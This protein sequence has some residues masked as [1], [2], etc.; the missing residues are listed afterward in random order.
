MSST[1]WPL[2][3]DNAGRADW[4]S[5]L[6]LWFFQVFCL[7]CVSSKGLIVLL[8]HFF[9]ELLNRSFLL[10][11]PF[12]S[13]ATSKLSDSCFDPRWPLL[14]KRTAK[15]GQRHNTK[16]CEAEDKYMLL[17]VSLKIKYVITVS[18]SISIHAPLTSPPFFKNVLLWV[19][20]AGC[21]PHNMT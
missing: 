20:I 16:K 4:K 1:F 14:H 18:F 17:S 8:I 9:L 13:N 11:K 19:A 3:T 2:A 12:K 5:R 7:L 15:A 21:R 10:E 6:R